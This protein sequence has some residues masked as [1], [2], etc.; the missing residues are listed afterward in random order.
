MPLQ[1][2]WGKLPLHVWA[3]AEPAPGRALR[4]EMDGP[5]QTLLEIPFWIERGRGLNQNL[6][7]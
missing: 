2:G 4:E 1:R 6:Q 3:D 7:P 5:S